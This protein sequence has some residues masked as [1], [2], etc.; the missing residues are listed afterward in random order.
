MPLPS[1]CILAGGRGTRLGA[2]TDETPKPLIAVGGKPFL[3]HILLSLAECGAERIVLSIGYLAEQFHEVLGDGSRFGLDVAYV[4]DGETPAGT[5]G[6][7]RNCLALLDD[8]FIVM[9]GDSLLRVDPGDLFSAHARGVRLATMAVMRSSL[10]HEAP[11]CSVHDGLV[12]AYAKAPPPADA[13]FIDYGMLVF[14]K[15]AFSG[16]EGSDLSELQTALAASG[17]LAGFEV[18]VPYT[19]IGT[20]DALAAA[21]QDLLAGN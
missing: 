15:K 12:T 2:L 3:E 16:F 8:P 18:T 9:Y 5:A 6:G 19:E 20:P 14:S 17:D 4:E 11:N 7:V 21:E 13:Q 10:G 1:I